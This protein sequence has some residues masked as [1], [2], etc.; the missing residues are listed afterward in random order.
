MMKNAII[1]KAAEDGITELGFCSLDDYFAGISEKNEGVFQGNTPLPFGVKTAIVFAFN[2]YVDHPRGNISRYAW[3]KDYHKIVRDR[4]R[5]I[6]TLLRKNGFAA[7]CYADTGALNERL[8]A[9]LSGIAF[10][11]KNR[12]AINKRYGSYFFI[13]Y[14]L[15]DCELEP[16]EENK[17]HC[18][19][20]GRCTQA[21]PLS[22]LD[23]EEFDANRCM[24][25]V[26]QKK[27]ELP[28]EERT[29]IGENGMIWGC[30][31]CQEVCPHNL[32]PEVTE[33]EEFK[34]DLITELRLEEMSNKE[35]LRL[36]GDRA[37]AWRGKNVLMRNQ[38]YVYIIGSEKNSKI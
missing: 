1:K 12:M 13:G 27:G 30:D 24:S 10:I 29:A 6:E 32:S 11:G 34:S 15:T 22:A 26:T 25:Y 38:K 5:P 37:F 9:R 16:D 3:G 17:G 20:C 23:G 21:C 2:Y 14:I 8:L 31:R 19:N 36:Y 35:F 7:E 28:E 33:I 18:M 4:M